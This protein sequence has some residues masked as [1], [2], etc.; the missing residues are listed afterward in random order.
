MLSFQNRQWQRALPSQWKWSGT[1]YGIFQFYSYCESKWEILGFGLSVC[2]LLLTGYSL[3]KIKLIKVQSNVVITI[4]VIINYFTWMLCC[5][6]KKR[7]IQFSVQLNEKNLVEQ[8]KRA[9]LLLHSG[10]FSFWDWIPN[11]MGVFQLSLLS[12]LRLTHPFCEA[13]TSHTFQG[14]DV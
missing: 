8:S 7:F 14:H 5:E 11:P 1:T 12:H 3:N 4:A 10:W 2:C 13:D 9:V 6:G